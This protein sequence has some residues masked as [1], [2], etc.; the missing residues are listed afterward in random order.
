MACKYVPRS[1]VQNG[2][3]PLV[4]PVML[5]DPLGAC[6]FDPLLDL[7]YL[8]FQPGFLVDFFSDE[9]LLVEDDGY[10]GIAFEALNDLSIRLDAASGGSVLHEGGAAGSSSLTATVLAYQ[11][12]GLAWFRLRALVINK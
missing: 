8:S 7:T 12:R 9:G 6:L 10:F 5:Q 2:V 1:S 11:E 3:C 4:H